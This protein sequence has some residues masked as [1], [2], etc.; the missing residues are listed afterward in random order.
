MG[1]S[2]FLRLDE[3]ERDPVH[4]ILDGVPVSALAGDTLLVAILTNRAGLRQF[5]F[6][7]ESRSG[8]CLMAACQDCWVWTEQGERLRS[9]DTPVRDGLSIVTQQPDMS[10]ANHA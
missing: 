7:T 6:R 10:W 2:R 8:F 9:C 3:R 5:E 1:V 4:F